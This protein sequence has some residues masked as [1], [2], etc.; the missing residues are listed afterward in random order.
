MKYFEF[1]MI[2]DKSSR[3]S[4]I[5]RFCVWLFNLLLP[6]ANPTLEG[7]IDS[8]KKWY[9]EYN[10]IY[11]YTNREIGI[12]KHGNIV[13]KAPFNDN[14]GYWCDNDLSISDYKKF[15]IQSISKNQFEK[16]W[17]FDIDGSPDKVRA[18]S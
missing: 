7:N 8:V 3:N 11:N 6:R 9:I 12:D 16:L 2:T 5:E 18:N 4:F 1:E 17:N 10:D 14:L 15:G 13:F